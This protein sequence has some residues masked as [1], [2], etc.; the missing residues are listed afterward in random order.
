MVE[1][2]NW[3]QK[4]RLLKKNP[5]KHLVAAISVGIYQDTPVLDLDY[6]ED[7]NAETD[8][9]V[10][11]TE[12]GEFIEIQGTAEGKPFQTKELSGMLDLARKGIEELIIRQKRLL[13]LP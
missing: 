2:F 1:A 8:M 6:A 10:I 9:N 5:L 13:D 12:H 7:S 4:R 3:M 11:M